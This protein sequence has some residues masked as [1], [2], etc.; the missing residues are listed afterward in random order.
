MG[1]HSGSLVEFSKRSIGSWFQHSLCCVLEGPLLLN[2]DIKQYYKQTVYI[3]DL[4]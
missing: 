3:E 2:F 4:T 1:E